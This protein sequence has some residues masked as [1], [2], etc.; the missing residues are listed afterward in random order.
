MDYRQPQNLVSLI[1]AAAGFVDLYLQ[2]DSANASTLTG[3]SLDDREPQIIEQL[4]PF[5]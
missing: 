3:W 4:M 2:A 5:F 1:Q